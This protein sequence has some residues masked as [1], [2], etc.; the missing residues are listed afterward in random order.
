MNGPFAVSETQTNQGGIWFCAEFCALDRAE[1]EVVESGVIP[2]NR[3][4]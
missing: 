4:F 1:P 2:V 3:N